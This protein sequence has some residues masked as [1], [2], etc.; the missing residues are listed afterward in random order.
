VQLWDDKRIKKGEAL[1]LYFLAPIGW[2]LFYI[3][4]VVE[5]RALVKA[6]WGLATKEKLAWQKWN[7][8]GIAVQK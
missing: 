1:Q 4:T 7:R 3:T 8:V 5:Y 6:I 2:L